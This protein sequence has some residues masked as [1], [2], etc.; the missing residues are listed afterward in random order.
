[1]KTILN[2]LK[3]I[4]QSQL[5]VDHHTSK[6]DILNK[7][8]ELALSQFNKKKDSDQIKKII[9]HL[10]W[11]F[12]WDTNAISKLTNYKPKQIFKMA[13]P[14]YKNT[15]C[16][17]CQQTFVFEKISR[18]QR[19]PKTCTQCLYQTYESERT[20]VLTKY[21]GKQIPKDYSNYLR[22]KHW[23]QRR[24]KAL[25]LA[26]YQCQ[27]CSCQDSVLEVHHN[28]YDNLGKEKDKDLIA[29][30]RP[31]HRKFHTK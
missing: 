30:C 18:A 17:Q 1:M 9:H 19:H 29:L 25:E 6:L 20:K 3:E 27:L 8:I 14:T 15:T 24:K 22:S 12:N 2:I 13:G 7:D 11:N 23:K 26:E 4:E 16:N 5:M 10:Y 21:L 28:N 31:C